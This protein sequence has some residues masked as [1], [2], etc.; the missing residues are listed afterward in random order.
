MENDGKNGKETN[1]T[2]KTINRHISKMVYTKVVPN[3]SLW[4]QM[5]EL[6]NT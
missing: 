6:G 1:M 4:L 3:K 5:A 2:Y